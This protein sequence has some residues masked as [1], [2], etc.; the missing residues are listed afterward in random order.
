MGE[1]FGNRFYSKEQKYAE[2]EEDL[3]RDGMNI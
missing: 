3:E 1:N 2:S